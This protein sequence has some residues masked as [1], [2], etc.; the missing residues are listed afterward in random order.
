MMAQK[1][2]ELHFVSRYNTQ[3]DKMIAASKAVASRDEAAKVDGDVVI[4]Y[5]SQEHYEAITGSF[6]MLREW[7]VTWMKEKPRW[8]NRMY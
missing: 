1:T 5:D 6:G 7:K 2:L 8:S 3:L 4:Q